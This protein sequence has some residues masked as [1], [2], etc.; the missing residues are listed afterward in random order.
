MKLHDF[1]NI[2]FYIL[3]AITSVLILNG[4]DKNEDVDQTTTS[5]I[6]GDTIR[7]ID[8]NMYNTVLIGN[9]CWMAE[10]LKT[11][12]YASD[13]AIPNVT[14][15]TAWENLGNNNTDDAYGYYDNSSTN[16]NIY[17]ALYTWA[18]AM[19]DNAVSSSINPSGVQGICPTGWHLPSDNEWKQLEM[20]LGMSQS[21]ADQDVF[22]GTN[23][24]SQLAGNSLLWESGSL[25]N[26]AQFGTSSFTA[27]PGSFYGIGPF[28]YLGTKGFW[29]SST[30]DDSLTAWYR[31]L[32]SSN[33]EV[34]RGILWKSEGLSV[35]CL[36]D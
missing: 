12:H 4:C 9:Q 35:R 19:G 33:S 22:R 32:W 25:E 3:L 34:D 10:N 1:R 27:L 23:Q 15:I 13:I 14:S 29:W 17:G 18:A 30:E 31:G 5:F 24:G 28:S 36:K 7:D 2:C 26:N 8:G 20:Q 11:T 16:A 21:E 6:C